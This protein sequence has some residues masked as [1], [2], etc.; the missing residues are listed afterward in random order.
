[1]THL[2]QRAFERA[3]ELPQEEQDK[4]ARF[5]LTEL[6]SEQRWAELF[7]HPKSEDLLARLTDDALMAHRAR[8]TK[9]LD[10][11]VMEYRLQNRRSNEC[12]SH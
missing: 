7:R 3:T 2:L 9:P 5:L 6:E 12:P 11:D 8:Q 4:F 1:M 10:G